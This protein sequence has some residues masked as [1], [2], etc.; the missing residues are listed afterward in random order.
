MN[1]SYTRF[2]EQKLQ[3]SSDNFTF[4]TKPIIHLVMW[5]KNSNLPL[6]KDYSYS[7]DLRHW[8][9]I[10]KSIPILKKIRKVLD[11]LRCFT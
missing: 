10:M 7:K 1:S 4:S 8:Q 2:T 9:S 3:T 6:P 5:L 11:L